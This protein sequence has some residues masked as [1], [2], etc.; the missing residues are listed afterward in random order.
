VPLLLLLSV[1]FKQTLGGTQRA[2]HDRRGGALVGGQIGIPTRQCQAIRV[3]DRILHGNRNAHVQ[4]GTDASNQH[5]LGGILLSKVRDIW[6]HYVKELGDDGGNTSK[7]ARS[8]AAFGGVVKTL[9]I[10]GHLTPPRSWSKSASKHTH[11]HTQKR[12]CAHI[13]FE[14]G[15]SKSENE[16]TKKVPVSETTE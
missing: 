5:A 1:V 11:T 6:F 8:G 4:I 3:S 14:R 9:L 10:L 16:S 2:V 15:V 13:F 7:V 12:K